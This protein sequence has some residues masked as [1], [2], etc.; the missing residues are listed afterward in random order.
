MCGRYSSKIS[1]NYVQTPAVSDTGTCR[2]IF[3]SVPQIVPMAINT[4]TDV[5]QLDIRRT[6]RMML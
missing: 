5:M 2:G 6:D 1:T 4:V 3:I